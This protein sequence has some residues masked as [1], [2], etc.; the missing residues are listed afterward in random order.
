MP[1]EENKALVRRF[2]EEFN[3]RNLAVVDEVIA[4]NYVAHEDAS[5]TW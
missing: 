2:Y 1:I 3:Q 4:S 5:L